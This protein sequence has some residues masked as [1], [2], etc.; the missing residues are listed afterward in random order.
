MT[1]SKL[2]EQAESIR[3]PSESIRNVAESQVCVTESIRTQGESIRPG[4]DS[5]V[6]G[7]ESIRIRGRIDSL[8]RID[9]GQ[10]RIDSETGL[11]S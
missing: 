3:P 5:Q 9:S 2:A 6:F 7:I 11:F 8:G 10:D 4:T 1:I